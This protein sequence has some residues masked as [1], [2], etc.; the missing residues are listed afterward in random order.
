MDDLGICADWSLN[1]WL[2]W[3]LMDLDGVLGLNLG[4]SLGNHGLGFLSGN[5]LVD[6]HIF[7][8]SAVHVI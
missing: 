7:K 8:K 3:L 2:R 1:D 6:M 5:C 4:L